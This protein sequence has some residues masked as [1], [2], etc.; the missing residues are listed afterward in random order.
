M[1]SGQQLRIHV[2]TVQNDDWLVWAA[3][4]LDNTLEPPLL[5]GRVRVVDAPEV[6]R[7]VLNLVEK[8]YSK[9]EA[10]YARWVE[11]ECVPVEAHAR[12]T[13]SLG[14]GIKQSKPK[15]NRTGGRPP[16]RKRKRSPGR[17][18]ILGML[19]VQ[20]DTCFWCGKVVR[21][22]VEQEHPDRATVEHLIPDSRG[23]GGGRENLRVACYGCNNRRGDR[24]GPMPAGGW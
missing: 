20:G 1:M 2:M 12:M 16:L 13:Q 4:V 5:H 8:R 9:N 10:T 21:L 7:H 17:H 6:K 18:R 22:D 19:R 23:G 24:V 11:E 15:T 3:V 14:L